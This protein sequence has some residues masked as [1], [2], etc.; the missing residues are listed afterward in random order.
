[1]VLRL[2]SQCLDAISMLAQNKDTQSGEPDPRYWR[3]ISHNNIYLSVDGTVKLSDFGI[4]TGVADDVTSGTPLFMSPE[5]LLHDDSGNNLRS[6]FYSLGMVAWMM[7]SHVLVFK[8]ISHEQIQ[9]ILSGDYRYLR[10]CFD[11]NFPN[12]GLDKHV[13]NVRQSVEMYAKHSGCSYDNLMN[14]FNLVINFDPE[15]RPESINAF[16]ELAFQAFTP[17]TDSLK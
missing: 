10:R 7:I 11:I 8:N 3:D 12:S 16:Y 6:E 1:M 13:L 2:I 4:S 17:L 5:R 9:A 14:F 15:N